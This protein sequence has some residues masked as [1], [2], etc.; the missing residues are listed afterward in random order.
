MQITFKIKEDTENKEV[1]IF[2]DGKVI[3]N[4]HTPSGTMHDVD[5][6]IQIC[7]FDDAFEYMSCG[8]FSNEAGEPKRD[9]QLM[10]SSDVVRKLTKFGIMD[11]KN[12]GKCFHPKKDCRC[13]DT[14]IKSLK[15]LVVDSLVDK[16]VRK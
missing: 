7:G 4:I 3:G 10:F 11:V 12:C 9:I 16:G 8:I 14:R 2:G 13:K 1:V 6:A 5:N 15:E